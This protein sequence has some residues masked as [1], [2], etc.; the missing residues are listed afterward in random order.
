MKAEKVEY[1]ISKPL[2]NIKKKNQSNSL[3][4]INEKDRRG[5]IGKDLEE[6]MQ[7]Q[8]KFTRLSQKKAENKM[9]DEYMNYLE[10]K[11]RKILGLN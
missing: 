1:K 11:G 9:N 6:E 4:E 3:M 2:M 8:P 7:I 5:M 10:E